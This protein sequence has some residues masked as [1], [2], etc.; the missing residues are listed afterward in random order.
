MA[1]YMTKKYSEPPKRTPG[2]S[3]SELKYAQIRVFFENWYQAAVGG[4]ISAFHI[5]ELLKYLR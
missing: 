3:G 5:S 1:I 4:S 2:Q